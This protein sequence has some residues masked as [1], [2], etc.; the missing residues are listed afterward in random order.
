MFNIH[1]DRIRTFTAQIS[2]A[3][4]R[5]ANEGAAPAIKGHLILTL[6]L[7]Q[8]EDLGNI[9]GA[10]HP[11]FGSECAAFENYRKIFQKI[12]R[13]KFTFESN[14]GVRRGLLFVLCLQ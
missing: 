3:G 9:L 4:G 5:E 13:Q 1:L 12:F 2:G 10:K 7:H 6:S 14:F 8:I 11:K